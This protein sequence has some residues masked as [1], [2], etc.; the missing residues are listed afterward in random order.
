MKL[1]KRYNLNSGYVQVGPMSGVDRWSHPQYTIKLPTVNLTVRI[2]VDYWG[3]GRNHPRNRGYFPYGMLHWSRFSRELIDTTY[4]PYGEREHGVLRMYDLLMIRFAISMDY[5]MDYDW[6]A[7]EC[8]KHLYRTT[9]MVIRPEVKK[10]SFHPWGPG[11]CLIPDN[12]YGLVHHG[13]S[14][15]Q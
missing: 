1:E 10:S 14:N 2:L 8:E 7:L 6:N 15:R 3:Y 11:E 5:G 9:P 13:Y 12:G 4:G